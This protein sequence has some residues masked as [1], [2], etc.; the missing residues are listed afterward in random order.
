M[1]SRLGLR[2]EFLFRLCL[3]LGREIEHML[4]H[5]AVTVFACKSATHYERSFGRL[6][7]TPLDIHRRLRN[8]PRKGRVESARRI[9]AI[10]LSSLCLLQFSTLSSINH[11][12][13]FL[14]R[15][16]LR[17]FLSHLMYLLLHTFRHIFFTLQNLCVA[18]SFFIKDHFVCYTKITL[19]HTNICYVIHVTSLFMLQRF[20]VS[21]S[22]FYVT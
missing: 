13:R 7:A 3:V 20:H 19:C 8:Y 2:A 11:P 14:L 5:R 21:K 1:R 18:R 15:Y 17:R 6:F 22:Y 4:Q 10:Q 9:D 12:L 16:F